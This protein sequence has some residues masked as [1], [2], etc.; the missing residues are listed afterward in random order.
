[1]I[2]EVWKDVPNYEGLYKVSNLGNVL[3]VN[4]NHTKKPSLLKSPL[5]GHGYPRVVLCKDKTKRS[6]SV[7]QLVAMAFLNFN[8]CGKKMVVDHIDFNKEN[9]RLD[10]LQVV[11]VR[12]NT[13]RSID[14]TKTTANGVG[15]IKVRENKFRSRININGKLIHIGYF[16]NAEDAAKAY[17]E[18]LKQFFLNNEL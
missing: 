13:V 1:M 15:V 6:F 3:S 18:R 16:N 4:Y 9:N 7:H 5:G 11:T 8:P 2:Q 10:N 14:Q 17:Q 12:R